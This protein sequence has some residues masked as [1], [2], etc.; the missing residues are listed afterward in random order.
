MNKKKLIVRIK[1]GLGN[2][3]FCYAA[4][5]RLSIVN[6]AELVIDDVTGF[7]RDFEYRRS[8]SLDNFNILCKK[9]SSKELLE[10]FGLIRRKLFKYM[11]SLKPFENR[12]F[13]EQEFPDFDLRLINLH[14][15]NDTYID[16]LWQSERYFSDVEDIIRCDLKIKPPIDK[17][18][19][20]F[21][22]LIKSKNS[23]GLHIRRFQKSDS[24]VTNLVERYYTEA[25]KVIYQQIKT[26]FF[27][28]FSDD[29]NYAKT[30]LDF[31]PDNHIYIS[32]NSDNNS[33]YA[34]LWLMS[35]CEHFITA[36]STFSWWGAWL[37]G[38]SEKRIILFPRLSED[39]KYLWS[40]DFRY[41]MPSNWIPINI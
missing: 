4:A 11:E 38:S 9:A 21:F 31:L 26:P 36:N 32:H 15:K 40:W 24:S 18:N 16:G 41:Q 30:L 25:I 7:I 3:L 17:K 19:K 28:V 29:I 10:P 35:H 5:R 2:Q 20:E 23:I 8:Y 12:S 22:Q 34:D 14:F 6:N 39:K 27:V 13:I 33:A 37:G 1:G